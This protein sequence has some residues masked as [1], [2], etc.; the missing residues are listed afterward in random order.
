MEKFE[1]FV[2]YDK[3]I[4]FEDS[5]PMWNYFLN[6][7]FNDEDYDF[8][9]FLAMPGHIPND[10]SAYEDFQ[11]WAFDMWVEQNISE[12]EFYRG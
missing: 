8:E 11:E 5:E 7:I 9:E 12:W 4:V 10:P 6:E 1:C 3:H 2:L